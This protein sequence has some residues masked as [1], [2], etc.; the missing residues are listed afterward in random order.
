MDCNSTSALTVLE[1]L[2]TQQLAMEGDVFTE[3]VALPVSAEMPE[4][5]KNE[6]YLLEQM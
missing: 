4:T 1:E 3:L 5:A 2:L 6:N